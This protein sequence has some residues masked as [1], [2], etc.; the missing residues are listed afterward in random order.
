MYKGHLVKVVSPGPGL[1]GVGPQGPEVLG[2][3]VHHPLLDL[4]RAADQEQWGRRDHECLALEALG[5]DHDVEDAR[6]ILQ[7][8]KDE[9]LGRAG[10]LAADDET[11]M[12]H[13][14]AVASLPLQLAGGAD[15]IRVEE[16][17][18]V[19]HGMSVE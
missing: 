9:P 11:G 16:C 18:Q 7:R 5:R 14:F 4:Q 6:F 10:A 19:A 2:A 12:C 8:E 17:A 1:T 15:P 3:Q 13:P